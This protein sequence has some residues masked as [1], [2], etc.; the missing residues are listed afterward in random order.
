M[1]L[2]S[3]D[4]QR[5]LSKQIRDRRRRRGM[6][7]Q[8]LAESAGVSLGMVSN[9]ERGRTTAQP[10]NLHAILAA[11][12][13]PAEPNEALDSDTQPP[14]K[15]PGVG[16]G[17][18]RAALGVSVRSLA[19]LAGVDRGRLAKIEAGAPGARP[20][21]LGAIES[22][23]TRLEGANGHGGPS[24]ATAT[25]QLVRIRLMGDHGV[26]VELE[27]PASALPELEASAARLV[28]AFTGSGDAEVTQ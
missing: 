8:E 15:S 16:L 25:D 18:R 19:E 11:L 9:L 4:R 23:L 5:Q 17:Q 1:T 14:V 10:A 6:T 22:A 2:S 28:R 7:Q 26:K 13:L 21:T 20:A 24:V 12:D 27:G 3:D